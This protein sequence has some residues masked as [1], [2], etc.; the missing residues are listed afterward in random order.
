[1]STCSQSATTN[2]KVCERERE[3]QRKRREKHMGE[4]ENVRG[5][6]RGKGK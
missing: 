5:E 1:M 6:E 2:M 3:K 4:R